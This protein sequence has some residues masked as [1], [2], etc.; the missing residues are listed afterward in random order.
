MEGLAF[1]EQVDV[2]IEDELH[3]F[4][5]ELETGLAEHE[6]EFLLECLAQGEDAVL[7]GVVEFFSQLEEHGL[8]VGGVEVVGVHHLQ[9]RAVQLANHLLQ[10]V[11]VHQAGVQ[12]ADDR[13]LLLAHLRIALGDDASPNRLICD[14]L[15]VDLDD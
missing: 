3:F 11:A 5:G 12:P 4:E 8:E 13:V 14:S 6:V 7:V 9:Q 15:L 1:V 10:D 2:G